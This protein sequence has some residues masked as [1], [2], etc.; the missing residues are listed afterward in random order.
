MTANITPKTL[1]VTGTTANDKTYDGTGSTTVSVGTVVGLVGSETLNVTA[2]GSFADVNVGTGKYVTVNYNLTDDSGLAANYSLAN[3]GAN[4]AIT[5]KQL[6]V[7]G[8]SVNSKIYDGSTSASVTGGTLTGLISG[9]TINFTSSA[10]FASA[11]AGTGK[12]ATISYTLSDATGSASN[13]SI[14]DAS[15]TGTITPKALSISA[16]TAQSRVYDGTVAATVSAGTLSGLISGETLGVT[17]TGS[18][19]SKSIGTGKAVS[20]T[21]NLSD[22]SGRAA[23]YSL[24]A[25]ST[26][27]DVTSKA[28]GLT[29]STITTKTYDGT[30]G[31][32]IAGLGTLSGVVSGDTVTLD[33][34]GASATFD[35]KNAGANK[36]VTLAGLSISGADAANYVLGA[37]QASGTITPKALSITTPQY[38][39]RAFN[40]SRVLDVE[41]GSLSGFVGAETIGVVANG[42][43]DSAAAGVNKM[44]TISYNLLNGTNGGLAGNYSLANDTGTVDI[45]GD[46]SGSEKQMAR[47]MLDT[48]VEAQEQIVEVGMKMIEMTVAEEPEAQ[49]ENFV[50]SMGQWQML[51]CDSDADTAMCGSR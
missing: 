31:A 43:L 36:L 6:S 1:A 34:A 40:G 39:G 15:T 26:N 50:E 49:P 46:E 2:S 14:A 12:A 18:F 20:V 9:E 38:E 7:S 37:T 13:Y 5:A 24:A 42:L 32:T 35:S 51:S 16:P 28:L 3:G 45:E 41:A 44:V 25:G 27:A 33:S 48:L 30:N 22:G 23:N 19:A 29:T 17:A 11:D 47:I 10:A 21:Y 4:A 8:A